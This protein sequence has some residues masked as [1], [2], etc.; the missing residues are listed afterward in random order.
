[1]FV[2]RR[3][4]LTSWC[5][6]QPTYLNVLFIKYFNRSTSI[7]VLKLVQYNNP[8]SPTSMI[9]NKAMPALSPLPEL[10]LHQFIQTSPILLTTI[11]RLFQTTSLVYVLGYQNTL[12]STVYFWLQRNQGH[13]FFDFV[14]FPKR[15]PFG[16]GGPL[17]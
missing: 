2:R 3:S 15:T 14:S 16:D 4:H 8:S 11:H 9:N 17:W 12:V 7:N 5:E 6:K 13:I 10:L 1:M